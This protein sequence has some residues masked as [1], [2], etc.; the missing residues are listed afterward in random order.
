MTHFVSSPSVVVIK[1]KVP[2]LGMPNV[3]CGIFGVYLVLFLQIG[4]GVILNRS[5]LCLSGCRGI[6]SVIM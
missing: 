5:V 2:N 6:A 3:L 1:F 4:I